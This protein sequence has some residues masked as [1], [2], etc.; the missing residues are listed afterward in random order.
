MVA[1]QEDHGGLLHLGEVVDQIL[2][3]LVALVHQGEVLVHRL[4]AVFQLP[5]EPHLLGQVRPRHLIG[6]VVL[7]GHVEEEQGLPLLLLLVPADQVLI[8]A[9]VGDV[10]GARVPPHVRPILEIALEIDL[11]EAVVGVHRGPVPAGGAVGVGGDGGIPQGLHLA[12]QGGVAG[13]DVHLVGH[14]AG[15]EE[16]GGVAG[17][18]LV[19]RV[20]G[21]AAEHGGV[22]VA[23]DGVLGE[24]AEK[25]HGVHVGLHPGE[26]GE[27]GEG[28]VHDHDH[29]HRPDAPVRRGRR[30]GG[31]AGA[32]PGQGRQ[33]L[34]GVAVRLLHL[35]VFQAHGEVEHQAVAPGRPHGGLDA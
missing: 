12:H 16:G 1:E 17:E 11:I 5:G 23:L 13:G 15:G 30:I 7:H 14:R 21:G 6:R 28:L 26:D 4:E 34:L 3:G 2:E 31:V 33:R 27:I 18:E 9:P 22:G 10:A 29:V 35:H 19:L 8:V 20:G 24:G 25:G 32:L